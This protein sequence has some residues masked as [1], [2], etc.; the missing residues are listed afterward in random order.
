MNCQTVQENLTL[1]FYEELG[2]EE[3]AALEAHLG[4]CPACREAAAELGRLR[5]VLDQRPG[6]EPSPELLVRCRQAL[7]DALDRE[8]GSWRAMVRGWFV[9]PPGVSALR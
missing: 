4:V 5:A 2:A 7:E 6:R 1:Y 3:R 8:A 9:V